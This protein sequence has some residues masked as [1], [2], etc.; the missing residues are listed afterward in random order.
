MTD[1][2]GVDGVMVPRGGVPTDAILRPNLSNVSNSD[3]NAREH[4]SKL[5][6]HLATFLGDTATGCQ[7]DAKTAGKLAILLLIANEVRGLL[8]VAG[9]LGWM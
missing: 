9:V 7:L 5:S 3:G 6:N 8:V 2:L 1:S 4:K